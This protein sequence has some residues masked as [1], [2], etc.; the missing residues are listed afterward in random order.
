MFKHLIEQ[1]GL[2]KHPVVFLSMSPRCEMNVANWGFATTICSLHAH[3]PVLED[4]Y[5]VSDEA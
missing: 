1:Q 5:R 3:D 4:V 2:S